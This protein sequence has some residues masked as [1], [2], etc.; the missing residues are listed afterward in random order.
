MSNYK[1]TSQEPQANMLIFYV[2]NCP[3]MIL[4][5]H[6]EQHMAVSIPASDA[7][8]KSQKNGF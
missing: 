6:Y 4:G 5:Q 8:P 3:E 2:L 1:K 7:E